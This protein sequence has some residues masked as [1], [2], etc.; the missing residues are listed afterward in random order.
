MTITGLSQ[1]WMH[2][3]CVCF[4]FFFLQCVCMCVSVKQGP[5][6]CRLRDPWPFPVWNVLNVREEEEG[7]PYSYSCVLQGQCLPEAILNM[8][9]DKVCKCFT[10]RSWK[11]LHF[12]FWLCQVAMAFDMLHWPSY[13]F[14]KSSVVF[15]FCHGTS[16]ALSSSWIERNKLQCHVFL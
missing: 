7:A 1:T 11:Y 3:L 12:T 15:C 13:N 16:V 14:M 6:L 8:T 4:F 2:D 5:A 9:L 10:E